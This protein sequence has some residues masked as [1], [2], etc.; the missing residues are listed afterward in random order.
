MHDDTI[1]EV[2]IFCGRDTENFPQM[3]LISSGVKGLGICTNCNEKINDVI[4]H[5]EVNSKV[6]EKKKDDLK[7]F[8]DNIKIYKP[9]EIKAKLDEYVIG[10]DS[11][12]IALSVAIY[13]HYKKIKN[14]LESNGDE[15]L[16]KSNILM[17]GPS[18]S[19]K[20]ISGATKINI[21]NKKTGEKI[22][23]TIDEFKKLC[24]LAD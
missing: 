13:N 6:E 19:G 8:I 21:R 9:K 14:N 16:D 5:T 15:F 2:C 23:I 24:G 12:K 3:K 20:C 4:H 18:A 1:N 7:K 10:Q 22:T 17:I 11:A